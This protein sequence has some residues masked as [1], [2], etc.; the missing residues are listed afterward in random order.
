MEI[1][2]TFAHAGKHN[3][4]AQLQTIGR[5]SSATNSSG[6][7]FVPGALINLATRNR[8]P[9]PVTACVWAAFPACRNISGSSQVT[10]VS[11]WYLQALCH[12]VVTLP[13]LGTRCSWPEW[14]QAFFLKDRRCGKTQLAR[15]IIDDVHQLKMGRH[16]AG[17]LLFQAPP[18]ISQ[19]LIAAQD[20]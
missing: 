16:R 1:I 2:R 11:V 20:L 13:N 12:D 6:A 14:P 7:C 4:R 5:G 8:G 3:I 10:L 17:L 19:H 18:S 9:K 15:A